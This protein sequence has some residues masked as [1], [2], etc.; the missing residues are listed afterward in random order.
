MASSGRRTKDLITNKTAE[1]TRLNGKRLGEDKCHTTRVIRAMTTTRR[2]A[3]V[4]GQ[5][6][7]QHRHETTEMRNGKVK[8]RILGKE[9]V[10]RNPTTR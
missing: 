1:I 2:A 3:M 7:H 10:M 6:P 9:E 5:V 4:T 8:I